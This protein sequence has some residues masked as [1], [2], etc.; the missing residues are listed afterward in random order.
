M[1]LPHCFELLLKRKF[2]FAIKCPAQTVR[3]ETMQKEKESAKPQRRHA[4]GR[5]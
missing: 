4:D 1:R 3:R 2:H 5:R